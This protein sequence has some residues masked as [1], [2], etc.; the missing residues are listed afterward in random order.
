MLG[1]IWQ[2]PLQLSKGIKF[3]FCPG[4][5]IDPANGN[6]VGPGPGTTN[7]TA[8]AG[9]GVGQSDFLSAVTA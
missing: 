5:K 2:T 8:T 1:N 9:S 4:S 3:R 6:S 7:K